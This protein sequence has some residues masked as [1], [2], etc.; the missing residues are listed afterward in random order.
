MNAANR[1]NL[2]EERWK[3]TNRIKKKSIISLFSFDGKVFKFNL[4]DHKLHYFY[5]SGE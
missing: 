3:K 5:T 1:A 2:N 4:Y